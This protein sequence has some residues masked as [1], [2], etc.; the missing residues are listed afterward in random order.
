ML[1]KYH[2]Y[3]TSMP[4]VIMFGCCSI[5]IP[6][7]KV[8]MLLFLDS[9]LL[10]L[11]SCVCVEPLLRFERALYETCLFLHVDASYH[12]VYMFGVCFLDV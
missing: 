1:V 6:C 2:V 11:V 3:F 9:L 12:V 7:S 5:Y 4:L 10:Y 8:T